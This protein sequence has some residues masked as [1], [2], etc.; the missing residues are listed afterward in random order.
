MGA[1]AIVPGKLGLQVSGSVVRMK[2]W[3]GATRRIIVAEAVE[4]SEALSRRREDTL[5]RRSGSPRMACARPA[6]PHVQGSR[7]PTAPASSH[8]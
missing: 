4:L 1:E 8:R 6:A 7:A 2:V 3:L 5:L